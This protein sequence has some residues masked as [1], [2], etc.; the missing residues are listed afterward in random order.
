VPGRAGR[1]AIP[2][3]FSNA[4]YQHSRGARLMTMLPA[5]PT[6]FWGSSAA[7]GH[8][9]TLQRHAAIGGAALRRAALIEAARREMR[10]KLAAADLLDKQRSIALLLITDAS[11]AGDEIETAGVGT[12]WADELG[13]HR[14]TVGDLIARLNTLGLLNTE[15]NGS[16]HAHWRLRWLFSAEEWQV[17]HEHAAA[18]VRQMLA[19]ASSQSGVMPNSFLKSAS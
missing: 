7:L 15:V 17:I 9:E 13:V 14:G 5:C 10:N 18:R 6:S 1:L 8:L 3:S 2:A 12:V 16:R 4:V 11:A 19:D